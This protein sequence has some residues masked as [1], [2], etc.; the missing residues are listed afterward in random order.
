MKNIFLKTAKFIISR[1]FYLALG[2]FLAIG[3]TYVYA[4]WDQAKTGG[5]G[6][7]TELNWNELVTMIENN[8]GTGGVTWK[9]YTS[10]TS[11]AMG[12]TM[13]MNDKCNAQYS[14]SHACTWD[15]IIKLGNTFD[16]TNA[17]YA[18]VVDGV[19]AGFSNPSDRYFTMLKDGTTYFTTSAVIATCT[20]WT[21]DSATLYGPALCV[22]T[23][24]KLC[25]Q[26]CS[27]VGAKIPCCK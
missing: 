23:S 5:S 22:T 7:L 18:W 1:L 9:G 21:S 14:G 13:G 19:Q 2:I 12:G 20:G 17:N 26:T 16:W 8:I 24:G 11:G 6:Q 4:T 15:E 27:T 3:A 25:T 10:P